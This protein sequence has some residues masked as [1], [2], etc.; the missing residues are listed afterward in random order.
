MTFSPNCFERYYSFEND[1]DFVRVLIEIC[2]E[3]SNNS[4][5]R[6][7]TCKSMHVP[8]DKIFAQYYLNDIHC[9]ENLTTDITRIDAQIRA[10]QLST[11]DGTHSFLSQS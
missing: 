10:L 4:F 7:E 6:L 9:V 2:G 11:T 8:I 3:E 1:I 5:I